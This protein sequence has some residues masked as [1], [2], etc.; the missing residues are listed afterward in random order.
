MIMY[1]L[2][3]H[4]IDIPSDNPAAG[5]L[6]VPIVVDTDSVVVDES[7]YKYFMR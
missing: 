7:N 5:V 6:G 2:N 4:N 1:Q 3:N